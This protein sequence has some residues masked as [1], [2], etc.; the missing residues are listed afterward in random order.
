MNHS[1]FKEYKPIQN[2]A[3]L[4]TAQCRPSSESLQKSLLCHR[5]PTDKIDIQQNDRKE[6][7]SANITYTQAGVSCFVGQLSSKIKVQFFVESAV[8]KIPACV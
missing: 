3:H 7:R 2:Q 4:Q 6:G 8:V 1:V 5:T